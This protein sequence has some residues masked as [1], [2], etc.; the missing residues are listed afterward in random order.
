MTRRSGPSDILRYSHL[1]IQFAVVVMAALWAGNQL[2]RRL[3]SGY[4][5]LVGTFVGAGLGFYFLYREIY[6]SKSG[7][8]GAQDP[9]HP[10]RPD[11]GSAGDR[12]DSGGDPPSD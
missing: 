10:G 5:T 12:R 4:F 11:G 8:S 9:G 3:G 2:D 7:D 6:R 1:G